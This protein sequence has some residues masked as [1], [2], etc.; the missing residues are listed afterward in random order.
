MGMSFSYLKSL[1]LTILFSFI[2]PLV[3]VSSGLLGLR[4]L[5]WVPG[6]EGMSRHGV[7]L[8]ITFLE[9]FG[10]GDSLQGMIVIGSTCA[11]VGALFDIFYRQQNLRR[12]EP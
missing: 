1:S 3:M 10:T 12:S 8:G 9:T 2:T 4:L 11:V 6:L 5:G 7:H